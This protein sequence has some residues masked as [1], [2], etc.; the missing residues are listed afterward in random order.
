MGRP[1]HAVKPLPASPMC[2][3]S[4][5]PL[6]VRKEMEPALKPIVDCGRFSTSW[7]ASKIPAFFI[8]AGR[9]DWQSFRKGGSDALLAGGPGSVAGELAMLRL[10]QELLIRNISPGGAADL[11]AATLF[12]DALEQGQNAIEDNSLSEEVSYGTD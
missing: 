8:V 6:C 4:A 5:F 2:C 9:R 7:L 1:E 11:L 12:L 10:D 3:T